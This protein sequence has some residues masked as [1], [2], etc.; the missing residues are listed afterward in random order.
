MRS[1]VSSISSEVGITIQ[2]NSVYHI[3]SR[4]DRALIQQDMQKIALQKNAELVD[5]LQRQRIL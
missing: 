3:D 4:T 1:S 2:D 5:K